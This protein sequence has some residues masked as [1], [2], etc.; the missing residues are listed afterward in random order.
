MQIVCPSGL[1]GEIRGMRVSEEALL[2]DKHLNRSGRL[3]TA[4]FE[5]CW[6]GTID[7]G[8]YRMQGKPD[9]TQIASVD[10]TFLFLQIR[11][12]S[13]GSAYTFETKCNN[14]EAVFAW[15][16]ELEDF[17]TGSRPM[18]PEGRDQIAKAELLETQ[19]P[20]SGSK[21]RWRVGIGADEEFVARLD[22]KEREQQAGSYSL[23]RNILD[24]DGKTNWGDIITS[25][26]ELPLRD[27]DVLRDLIDE[28]EGGPKLL[29]PIECNKC[30]SLQLTMLPFGPSFL[31]SRKHLNLR[32]EGSAG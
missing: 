1:T 5:A 26:S 16:I 21:V 11:I 22:K 32:S 12:A 6:C 7:P 28:V 29:F 2:T 9:F 8:P 3:M 20:C 13:Y 19:L 31:S 25:V 18:K 15:E 24:F 14:C 4:L 10:R 17:V 30:G 23:A 27:G